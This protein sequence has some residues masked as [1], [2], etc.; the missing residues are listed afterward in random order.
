M[1][2][3]QC[4]QCAFYLQLLRFLWYCVSN[5]LLYYH[6]SLSLQPKYSSM[7]SRWSSHPPY[8]Y[9][10]LLIVCVFPKSIIGML[11]FLLF[12]NI[13]YFVHFV[14]IM[15]LIG[16]PKSNFPSLS[17][18]IQNINSNSLQWPRN[19]LHTMIN[20]TNYWHDVYFAWREAS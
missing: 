14:D 16:E 2:A 18:Q 19:M 10:T 20:S 13:M 6:Y 17:T 1:F 5:Y 7:N 3:G 15:E 12:V 11:I 4:F 9:L 8:L